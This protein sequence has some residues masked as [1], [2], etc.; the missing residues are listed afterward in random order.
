MTI[1]AH[2]HFWNYQLQRDTWITEE[3]SKIRRDFLPDDLAPILKKNLIEGCM[4][5]QADQSEK[6]TDFLIKCA[7]N[8]SFIKGIVGWTDFQSPGVQ[9]RLEYYYQFQEVRGFRHVVQAEPDDFLSNK[10]FCKGVSYLEQYNYTYDILIYPQ[11]LSAA[12]IFVKKFPNQQFVIDH[13]AKPFIRQQ[14]LKPWKQQLQQIAMHENV[15]C[16]ISGMVTEADWKNWKVS[17]FKPYLETV[18]EA[19]GP[20]R[21]MYGSDWPVCLVGASYEDQLAI[22]KQFI[23]P[24]SPSEKKGILGGNAERFYHL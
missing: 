15:Y 13:L 10:N 11:Q 1:D 14:Q 17:D 23:E 21:L 12:L 18:L 8:N 6:E 16:K 7:R 19:F 5:V 3:M 4:A 20:K 9:A 22:V 24:L 2:Q